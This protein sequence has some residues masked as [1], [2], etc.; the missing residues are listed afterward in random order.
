MLDDA[1]IEI[2][3]RPDGLVEMRGTFMGR[4]DSTY[5]S[6]EQARLPREVERL[7]RELREQAAGELRRQAMLHEAALFPSL[8]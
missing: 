8:R 5:V 3:L 6:F 4:T 2:K 1:T 7:A